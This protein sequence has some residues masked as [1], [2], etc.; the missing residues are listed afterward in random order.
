MVYMSVMKINKKTS[1]VCLLFVFHITR[2][3]RDMVSKPNSKS[4]SS[5]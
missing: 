5:N 1:P 2:L 4:N 3:L